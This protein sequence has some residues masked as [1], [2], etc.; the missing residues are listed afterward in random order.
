MGNLQYAWVFCFKNNVWRYSQWKR[1]FCFMK[2]RPK[3]LAVRHKNNL[4]KKTKL[5][6]LFPGPQTE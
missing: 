3:T 2:N 4:T 5:G 1:E 6:T